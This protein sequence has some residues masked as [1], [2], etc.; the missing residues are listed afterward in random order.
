MPVGLEAKLIRDNRRNMNG[1]LNLNK[2]ASH[3]S[4][5]V[6]A[7]TRGIIKERRIGHLGT[8][9]PMATGVLPLAIGIATRLIE[10]TSFTKEYVA[11]CLLGRTTDSC[12]VTGKIL[13]EKPTEFLSEIN[14]REETGRLRSVTQQVPPMVSAVKKG[15]QKL[16]ELARKGI[17][18]E[19]EARPVQINDV[20]VLQIKIPRVTFRISCSAGTYVR[21]LCLSLGE[22]LGV[23]GCLESLERTRVGPLSL[24]DA[25]NLDEIKQ[26]ARNNTLSDVLSPPSLLVQHLPEF[27]LEGK[28]LSDFCRGR[29]LSFSCLPGFYRILNRHGLLCAIGVVRND[30]RLKPKKVFG[31]EGI[32]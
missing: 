2:P 14:V 15:G 29:E 7:L 4:H 25:L 17:K 28:D 16:Y 30:E 12:D 3:T 5:D 11:T 8:L 18:V 6:V 23:G 9:D 13:Q 1:I 22:T 27:I 26:K 32:L 10:F 21:V 31:E 24:R 19:R 20:E